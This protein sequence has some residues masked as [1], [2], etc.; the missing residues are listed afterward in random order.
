MKNLFFTAA[1]ILSYL[2]P[3]QAGNTANPSRLSVIENEK[4]MI[5]HSSSPNNPAEALTITDAF[6]EIIFSHVI[7]SNKK[8]I[9][10]DL[11]ALPNAN[12]TIRVVDSKITNI[13]EAEI[14]NDKI[15]IVETKSYYRPQIDSVD[16]KVVV[17][18][19]LENK[20]DIQILIYDKSNV[21]VFEQKIEKE[22][23]FVRS[24]NLNQLPKGQYEVKLSSEYFN[25]QIWVTL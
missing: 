15:E 11:K 19:E 25:E 12:Y 9:K 6:G 23:S 21:L 22:H 14:R 2:I 20:E 7:E 16:G 4:S 10:Y 24:F 1:F 3:I 17:S 13:Y 5:L 18:A 8:R